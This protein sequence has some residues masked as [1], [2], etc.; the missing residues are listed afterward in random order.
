M[1]RLN[2]VKIDYLNA[3]GGSE[4]MKRL[5]CDEL[6]EFTHKD[7]EKNYIKCGYFRCS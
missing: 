4:L 2:G 6:N 7:S 5:V 3:G 1:M